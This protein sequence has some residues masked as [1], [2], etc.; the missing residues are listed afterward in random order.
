MIPMLHLSDPAERQRVEALLDTLR[1]KPQDIVAG[2][3]KATAAVEKILNDV[4]VRGDDAVVESSRQFDDPGFAAQQI[5][6]APEEMKS[7]AG[8]VSADVLA[9]LRRSIAQ[10]RE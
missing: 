8:R 10:V 9:A 1:L 3:S 5:R 6:V 2:H 7:A 4:A